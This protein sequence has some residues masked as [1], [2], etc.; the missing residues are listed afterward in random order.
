MNQKQ[1]P[2]MSPGTKETIDRLYELSGSKVS[3]PSFLAKLFAPIP[4][5]AELCAAGLAPDE[6][7]FIAGQLAAN[8]YS[9]VKIAEGK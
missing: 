3:K 5:E 4:M 1:A 9:L 7:R 6:A 2:R 8:G